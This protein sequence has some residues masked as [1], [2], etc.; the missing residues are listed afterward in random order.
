MIPWSA[1]ATLWW[2]RGLPSSD[3][4]Q[5]RVQVTMFL[6]LLILDFI[7]MSMIHSY[8][9]PWVLKTLIAKTSQL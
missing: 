8:M 9:F 3:T 2:N 6:A 7:T 1:C 5:K 4:A